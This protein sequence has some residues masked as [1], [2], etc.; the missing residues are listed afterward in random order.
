MCHPYLDIS[1]K[2]LTPTSRPTSFSTLSKL[3]IRTA[4]KD[5]DFMV[6]F[7]SCQLNFSGHTKWTNR[8]DQ[9]GRSELIIYS[10]FGTVLGTK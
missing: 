8:K 5:L 1:K 4:S 6:N 10:L 2:S 3:D 7:N 9:C